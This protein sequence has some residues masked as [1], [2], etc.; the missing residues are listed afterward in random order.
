VVLLFC[1]DHQFIDVSRSERYSWSTGKWWFCCL[2]SWDGFRFSESYLG[3]WPMY[4][5]VLSINCLLSILV[6]NF[7]LAS[8]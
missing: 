3:S 2:A 4:H 8:W 6:L 7:V 5:L 1:D